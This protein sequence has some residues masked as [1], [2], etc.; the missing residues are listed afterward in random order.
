[1]DGITIRAATLAD[2]ARM[3]EIYAPYVERTAVSFEY[4]V[5]SLE[6]FESRMRETIKRYPWLA[7]E[8]NGNV[9]G[10]AYAGPFAH[11][12]AYAWAC[13]TTI[14]L[15][16]AARGR[17]L[18]RRLYEALEAK[19]GEMGVLNLCACIAWVDVPDAHL[20]HA[21]PDF[22]AHLGYAKVAHFHQCGYKFGRW[23]DMIWMEKMIGPHLDQQRPRHRHRR[24]V[25]R[26]Q[27]CL[28]GHRRRQGHR[29][30][31]RHCGRREVRVHRHGGGG[32]QLPHGHRCGGQD[33]VRLRPR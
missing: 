3:R 21:S 13:E 16:P 18:G 1:M 10:Y 12:A 26:H 15:D 31:H 5:P 20:D 4:E 11:R 22:H 27:R 7:I 8:E 25:Q 17:G 32:H 23:Y 2:A 19:L 30:R 24:P 9:L 28:Q 6:E 33:P 29:H 14:Y